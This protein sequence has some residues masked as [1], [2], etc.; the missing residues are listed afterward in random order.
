MINKAMFPPPQ[1]ELNDFTTLVKERCLKDGKCLVK[2]R[3]F[4][5]REI[6]YVPADE[7]KGQPESFMSG[8]W[9]FAW[10]LNGRS[11]TRDGFDMVFMKE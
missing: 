5:W 8:D 1:D 9:S 2:L 11:L 7:A 10:Y 6:E 4:Q 3:D